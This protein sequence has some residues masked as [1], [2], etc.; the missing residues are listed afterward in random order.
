[1]PKKK[2]DRGSSGGI[3]EPKTLMGK[4]LVQEP[5]QNRGA[6]VEWTLKIQLSGKRTIGKKGGSLSSKTHGD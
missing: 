4:S 2:S 5:K 3:W 1:M 6:D